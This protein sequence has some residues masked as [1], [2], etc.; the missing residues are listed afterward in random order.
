MHTFN[1]IYKIVSFIPKGKV[2]TYKQ[3]ALITGINNPRIVGFALHANKNPFRI[4][5]HRVIKSNGSIAKGYA[6]GGNQIQKQLLEKEGI[7]FSM[8]NKV[9]LAKYL[10]NPNDFIQLL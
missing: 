2:S 1:K 8:E 7:I 6:F 10:L 9:D 5:C 4:P 3:I